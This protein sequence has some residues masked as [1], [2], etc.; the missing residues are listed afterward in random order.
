MQHVMRNRRAT[1]KGAEE[2]RQ[3]DNRRFSPLGFEDDGIEFRAGKKRE[4]DRPGSR[5]KRDPLCVAGQAL[6]SAR[7]TPMTSWATVPTTISESAV[8]TLNQIASSVAASAR[9]THSADKAQVFVM[10]ANS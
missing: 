1:E 3:A 10:N 6:P 9:P 5:Q 2:S 4:D 8:E 7:K